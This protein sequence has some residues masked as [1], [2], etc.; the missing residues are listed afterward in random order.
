MKS[1]II[2]TAEKKEKYLNKCIECCLKQK[3]NK[4]IIVVYSNLKNLNDLKKKFLKKVKFLYVIKK[5]I[6]IHDQLYKIK[7]ALNISNGQ[8][9]YLCDGDD[10]FENNKIKILS[11]YLKK[12]P[13]IH[14][15]YFIQNKEKKIYKN[16]KKYKK[17]KIFKFLFNSWPDKICTSTIAIRKS[18]LKKFFNYYKKFT[19][20]YLAIDALVIIFFQKKLRF[21]NRKLTIKNEE[22]SGIDS[23]FRSNLNKYILRRIEQHKYYDNLYNKN[24]KKLEYLILKLFTFIFRIF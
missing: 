5:K 6:P 11:K 23:S 17:L 7:K 4:E 14:H 8:N 20:K 3:I 19:Y 12:N 16:V 2:I 24:N 22:N 18:E 15:D 9:I 13:V 10:Y 1:T 21:I